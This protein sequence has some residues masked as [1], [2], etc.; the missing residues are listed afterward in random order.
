M[1]NTDNAEYKTRDFY[2][3]ASLKALGY[4]LVCMEPSDDKKYFIFVFKDPEDKAR[5]IIASFWNHSL[6]LNAVDFVAAIKEL[7]G[8]LFS[9]KNS[10]V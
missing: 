3:A 8:Y 5:E 6:Q 4:N 2:H 7:K 10:S 1:T 9:V